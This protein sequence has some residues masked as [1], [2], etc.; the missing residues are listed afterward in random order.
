MNQ[1][2]G[3]TKKTQSGKLAQMDP[4]KPAVK[5]GQSGRLAHI[6]AIKLLTER[7]AVLF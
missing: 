3:V 7:L 6:K 1:V 5:W 4:T 2:L